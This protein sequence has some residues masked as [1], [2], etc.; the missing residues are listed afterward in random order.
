MIQAQGLVRP[1][2]VCRSELPVEHEGASNTINIQAKLTAT[3]H[4]LRLRKPHS[5][6]V[7]KSP[8]RLMPQTP[9]GQLNPSHQTIFAMVEH[10]YNR[11]GPP[12]QIET[13]AVWF[14]FVTHHAS[15]IILDHHPIDYPK[16]LKTHP[17]QTLPS[18]QF[19][20]PR[21]V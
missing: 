7:G 11:V 17:L 9:R 14:P 2:D 8:L 20:L 1:V 16:L 10:M 3:S 12:L 21:T 18:L 15:F 5:D 19:F 4:S 13:H 6:V